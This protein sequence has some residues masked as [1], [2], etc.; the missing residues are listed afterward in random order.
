M[1]A[2][3]KRGDS[4]EYIV[5]RAKVLPKPITLTFRDEA[6]G[7]AYVAQLEKLLDAGIVPEEFRQ[8]A[9][10]KSLL[11]DTIEQYV[12]ANHITPD[13]V[14]LLKNIRLNIGTMRISDIN[15]PWAEQWVAAM[16]ANNLAPSTIRK[17]VGALARCLDWVM[18]SGKTMLAMNPLR[19]LPKRY[20]TTATG[21]KDVERDRRLLPGEQ[22]RIWAVLNREK[23]EGRQRP[24]ELPE[25]VALKLM[26]VLALETAMR[27][28]EIYTL[29]GEQVALDQRTIFLEKTKNGDKRQVPL[30]S[31]AIAALQEYGIKAGRLFPWWDGRED[32]RPV[33]TRLSQQW[34]RIFSAAGC[35]DLRFHDLRHEA[36]SRFFERT[37]LTDVQISRITGHKNLQMLRRYSN[38]RGSDLAARLW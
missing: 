3:R 24:L 14:G 29:T 25:A 1:A 11:R 17:Y 26:F 20:A 34:Q 22:E 5:K 8:R 18:R 31:V 27:M 13:D 19:S 32:Y 21:R 36:T 30:S 4:W 23:P 7:D 9:E 15:Y 35:E 37:T 2:K 33:T 12:E 6:Q 38:L 10:A 16:R 28:R